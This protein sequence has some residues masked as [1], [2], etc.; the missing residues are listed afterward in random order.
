MKSRPK[1]HTKLVTDLDR[2]RNLLMEVRGQ[3]NPESSDLESESWISERITSKRVALAKLDSCE[4]PFI[5]D[6]IA[7]ASAKR[8]DVGENAIEKDLRELAEEVHAT[9]QQLGEEIIQLEKLKDFDNECI[10][11]LTLYKN[12]LEKLG[13]V[14]L[15]VIAKNGEVE[16][17]EEELV[18]CQAVDQEFLERERDYESLTGNE[19]MMVSFTPQE[20]KEEIKRRFRLLN[21]TRTRLKELI[22]KRIE[23][24]RNLVAEQQTLEGWLKSS[25]NLVADAVMLLEENETS[26]TLDSNRMSERLEALAAHITKI[27]EYL[28]YAGS[29]QESVKA[30]E[31]AKVKARMSELKQLLLNADNDCK[32]FTEDCELF[33]SESREAAVIFE[34]SAAE[35]QVPVSLQD[36]QEKLE[37]L[38]VSRYQMRSSL[39]A[40]YKEFISAE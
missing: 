6:Q 33:E 34:R 3:Q 39:A 5:T 35:H 7:K 40:C 25:E 26:V 16:Q 29:F 38:K 23:E 18:L 20:R 15:D 36:A 19:D 30:H 13:T 32:H 31:V 28:T 1:Q 14:D 10:A 4:L 11:L 17:T 22:P 9:Q 24:L 12:L 21:E 27:D 2:T 37:N 8:K